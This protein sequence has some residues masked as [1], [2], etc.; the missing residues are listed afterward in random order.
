MNVRQSCKSDCPQ[1][2]TMN[3]VIYRIAGVIMAVVMILGNT[4]HAKATGNAYYVSTT[5]NDSNSRTA[6]APFRTFAKANSLLKAGG[7]LYIYAGIYN[8][9]LRITNSGTSSAGIT[10]QPLGGRAIV[11]VL[12][13]TAPVLDVR[14]SYIT[15]SELELRN[16]TDVCVNLAGSNITISGLV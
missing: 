5:G 12:N 15:I 7:T 1:E 8:Q 11:D 4:V 10:V 3:K 2:K 9:Q 13:T 6:T 14:A 16:S